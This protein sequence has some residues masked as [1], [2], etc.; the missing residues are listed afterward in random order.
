[1]VNGATRWRP[2]LQRNREV[3]LQTL[4]SINRPRWGAALW[5]CWDLRQM[6][7]LR[8][9]VDA[10]VV[11]CSCPIC[12]LCAETVQVPARGNREE[13]GDG[14]GLPGHYMNKSVNILTV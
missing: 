14:D 8:G 11:L 6:V 3:L 1:M 7:A 5:P 2:Y 13:D 4:L 9:S 10:C 12:F